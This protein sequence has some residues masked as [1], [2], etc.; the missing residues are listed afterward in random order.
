MLSADEVNHAKGGSMSLVLIIAD[1]PEDRQVA[2]SRGLELAEKMG[3]GAQV[4]G[5]AYENLNEMGLTETAKREQVKKKLLARRRKQVDEEIARVKPGVRLA[6]SVVWHKA[7]HLWVDQQC[8]RKEYAAIVKTGHRTESFMYTSTD[9]HLLRECPAPVI[10]A[11]EKKWRAT[12][13]IVAAVDLVSTTRVNRQLTDV[14]ISTAKRYAEALGCDLYVVHAVHIPAVLTELDLVDEYTHAKKR[15]EELQ[16]RVLKLASVHN[17]PVSSIRLKEGPVDKVIT[18][19]SAR[20]KAQLVVMGT[21]GRRGVRGQLIGNTAEK[22]LSRLKTDV[23]AIK[24]PP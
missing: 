15:R 20:L 8:A 19:E 9:W 22:V 4:V 2:I 23:L 12:K 17:L 7:I 24:P 14:V 6:V 11:A 18:S 3:W 21:I 1:R 16:P 10:I 5:F 13:P